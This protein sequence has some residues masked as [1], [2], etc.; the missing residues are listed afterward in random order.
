MKFLL[1]SDLLS[2]LVRIVCWVVWHLESWII[3]GVQINAEE[4]IISVTIINSNFTLFPQTMPI[5]LLDFR[6]LVF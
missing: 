3:A 5:D 2:I 4:I 6:P 1:Q